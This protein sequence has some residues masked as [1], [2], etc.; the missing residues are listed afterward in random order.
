MQKLVWLVRWEN[1]IRNGTYNTNHFIHVCNAFTSLW[2]GFCVSVYVYVCASPR[3]NPKVYRAPPTDYGCCFEKYGAQKRAGYVDMS[4]PELQ[5]HF[6]RM[7]SL[8]K[9]TVIS[10]SIHSHSHL[11]VSF[12]ASYII[13]AFIFSFNIIF[14]FDDMHPQ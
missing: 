10:A 13:F 1:I 12:I 2:R 5:E 14:S 11:L 6:D 9:Y 4:C 7:L 3:R 8:A